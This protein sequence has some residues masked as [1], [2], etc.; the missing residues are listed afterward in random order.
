MMSYKVTE[1]RREYGDVRV[2]DVDS[3]IRIASCNPPIPSN[4]CFVAWVDGEEE[5]YGTAH[6]HTREEARDNMREAI[7]LIDD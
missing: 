4:I 6:G 5:R 7:M 3:R 2:M 1:V